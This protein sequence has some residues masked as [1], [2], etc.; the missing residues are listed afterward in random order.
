MTEIRRLWPQA[1]GPL[2]DDALLE[3]Y[4]Y[5]DA[6]T[7]RM[8]F[9]S[10][11]DGAATVGGRS[12]PL[13]GPG[14]KRIFD[15][16]RLRCDALL[17]G[18]NTVRTEKY[19]ALRPDP[20]WREAHGLTPYP[21]MVILS[22]SLDLDPEQAIFADAPRPPLILAAPGPAPGKLGEVAEMVTVSDLAE[23]PVELRRRGATRI[24]CEG[25]P[26]LFGQLIA[27]DLV[28]ELCL[29][30]SPLL[31]GGSAGR[32][33]TGPPTE[34]REMGLRQ[35]L[36]DGHQLFLRYAVRSPTTAHDPTED[37]AE[38]IVD[39]SVDDY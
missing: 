20:R 14:D 27:A 31:A 23:V 9:V 1:G 28:D 29:T 38:A 4:A 24:L 15:M 35:V 5:P 11:A 39:K 16:L 3:C 2:D 32:I 18:A 37:K 6:P 17:V 13:G 8:N 36:T 25:G 10:S 7:L 22:H 21:L 12:G 33:A 34:A 26:S 30:V 19:D